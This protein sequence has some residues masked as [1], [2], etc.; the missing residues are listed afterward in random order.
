MN[1]PSLELWQAVIRERDNLNQQNEELR[2]ENRDLKMKYSGW[3]SMLARV[4]ELIRLLEKACIANE[5]ALTTDFEVLQWWNERKKQDEERN[6]S[7]G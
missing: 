4:K 7:A 1:N 3:D 6:K 2:R 5:T